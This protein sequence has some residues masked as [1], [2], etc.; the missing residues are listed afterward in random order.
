MKKKLDYE[1]LNNKKFKIKIEKGKNYSNEDFYILQKNLEPIEEKKEK[2]HKDKSN[3]KSLKYNEKV[4]N[5]LGKYVKYDNNYYLFKSNYYLNEEEYKPL[6]IKSNYAR[7]KYKILEDNNFINV[8][9]LIFTIKAIDKNNTKLIE[10][11]DISEILKPYSKEETF[12]S[13]LNKH[14]Y[15]K[16]NEEEKDKI[17]NIIKKYLKIIFK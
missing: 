7:K 3:N 17:N 5:K 14:F 16:V 1:L 9:D 10:K 6:K 2:E 11:N 12:N 4:S 8:Y 13:L 15:Y